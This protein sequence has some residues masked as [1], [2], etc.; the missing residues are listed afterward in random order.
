MSGNVGKPW[1]AIDIFGAPTDVGAARRGGG[2]APEALRIAGLQRRLEGLD[3]MVADLGNLEGPRNPEGVREGGYR[4]LREVASWCRA[5]RDAMAASVRQGR[6]PLLLGG[7]HSLAIGSLAGIAGVCAETNTPL[8]TLWLDAHADFNTHET[9]STGNLHGM[10]VAVLAGL[11]PVDLVSLGHAMPVID[12]SRL[13]QVGVRSVDHQEK[14][15]IAREAIAI[16]DMRAI[17]ERGMR[18]VM[19]DVLDR[20]APLGGHLHIS[21]DVDFLDP[22]IAPGVATRVRGGPDYREAQL[23]MEMIHDTGLAS[24]LD[25]VELNPACDDGNATAELV[26]DLVASLFGERILARRNQGDPAN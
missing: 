20:V 11:G 18:A 4:H 5:V 26:V 10:P 24:S 9:S 2:M 3:L 19:A 13:F 17:D 22:A 25:I 14:K 15:N 8:C 7:D 21:F 16:H 12:T 23:C 1:P 6:F